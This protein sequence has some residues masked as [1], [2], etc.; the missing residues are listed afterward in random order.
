MNVIIP[1]FFG[2]DC[3]QRPISF[4][5]K[6]REDEVHYVW[7]VKVWKNSCK[8]SHHTNYCLME[9][10][11]LRSKKRTENHLTCGNNKELT[12]LKEGI[13]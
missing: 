11:A 8:L 3:S 13:F 12:E 2:L 7:V 6:V 4:T 5:R 9:P 10:V 1:F